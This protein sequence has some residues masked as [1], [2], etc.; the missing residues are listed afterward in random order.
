MFVQKV[1]LYKDNL[2]SDCDGDDNNHDDDGRDVYGGY[3]SHYV[4]MIL[5]TMI[6]MIFTMTMI[7]VKIITIMFAQLRFILASLYY[8]LHH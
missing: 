3:N 4:I 8:H 6:L 2:D 7:T 1:H 5:M